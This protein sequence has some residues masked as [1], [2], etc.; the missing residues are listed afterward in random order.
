MS[1]DVNGIAGGMDTTRMSAAAQDRAYRQQRQAAALRYLTR[2]GLGDVAVILG[3]TPERLGPNALLP[4][5]T[6]S[7]RR[8]HLAH[9]QTCAEC[10]VDGG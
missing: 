2:R 8:R 7:A 3:L 10:G 4:C 9:G 1:G 5:G 6:E